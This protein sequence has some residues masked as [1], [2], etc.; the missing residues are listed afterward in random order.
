MIN[1]D[2][3][4]H[5]SVCLDIA[6]EAAMEKDEERMTEYIKKCLGDLAVIQ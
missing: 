6:L 3:L 4:T 2:R 1:M 5:A